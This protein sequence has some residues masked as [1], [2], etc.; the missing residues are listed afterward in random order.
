MNALRSIP[1]AVA[2]AA[3]VAA[4]APIHAEMCVGARAPQ[5][6]VSLIDGSS[7]FPMQLRDKVVLTVFWATWCPICMNELPAYQTLYDRYRAEGFEVLAL[8]V[9]E[10][11]AHVREYLRRSGL[12]FP[13]AMRTAALKAAWGPV[14]GTPLLF[15]SDRK[16]MVRVRY[17]GAPNLDALERELVG[18]LG[19][20]Q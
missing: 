11:P 7:L 4:S 14:A 13:V 6:V 12:S 9:D 19:V 18:L 3:L 2:L 15:L 16:G 17:L 10:D 5:A 20:R 1:F 8:S